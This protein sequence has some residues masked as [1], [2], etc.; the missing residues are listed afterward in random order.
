[1]ADDAY[2]NGSARTTPIS[3][4]FVGRTNGLP[5]NGAWFV[6]GVDT[7]AFPL[8][9]FDDELSARRWADEHGYGSVVFWR[10]GWEWEEV[11]R[12]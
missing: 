1:M 10:F 2:T 4:E 5:P 3:F 11:S 12:W 7:C 8:A 6:Y 9:L